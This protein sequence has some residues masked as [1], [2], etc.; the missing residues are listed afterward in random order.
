MWSAPATDSGVP[1][2]PLDNRTGSDRARRVMVAIPAFNEE[3]FIGSV[4]LRAVQAGFPVLVI[5]D[6]SADNTAAI[7]EA[8]GARVERHGANRGKAE[9]LNTALDL[10]RADNVEALVVLDGDG[11]HD[12]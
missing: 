8:A 9:A 12:A 10:A 6:G 7:A 5:D 11:Q 1:A 3:R 2:M 4:V